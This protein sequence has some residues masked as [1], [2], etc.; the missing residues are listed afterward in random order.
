MENS[1]RRRLCGFVRTIPDLSAFVHPVFLDP[2]GSPLLQRIDVDRIVG[3]ES[4]RADDALELVS[5]DFFAQIGDECIA[6]FAI[7]DRT[8]LIGANS[9]LAKVLQTD[10][11]VQA[12]LRKGRTYSCAV[13]ENFIASVLPVFDSAVV[14]GN[15]V[16]VSALDPA[17]SRPA[18]HTIFGDLA[19]L[20]ASRVGELLCFHFPTPL[21][22][23]AAGGW[24][25]TTTVL[26]NNDT[27][28]LQWN[29][30]TLVAVPKRV[31][32]T[33]IWLSIYDASPDHPEAGLRRLLSL[34]IVEHEV[35]ANFSPTNKILFVFTTASIEDTYS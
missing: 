13:V 2:R 6:G 4:Y 16:R 8:T 10:M 7:D 14:S 5:S 26:G 17:Q 12:S 19:A 22:A 24:Q 32:P 23:H 9:D 30:E 3:W 33:P 15:V 18:R 28:D 35:V 11:N 20:L 1:C 31:R 27:V 25:S 21:A 29:K 34:S